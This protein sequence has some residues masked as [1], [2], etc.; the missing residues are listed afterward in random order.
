MWNFFDRK[1]CLTADEK[2]WGKA[3]KEFQ[4]V[5]LNDV[6]KFNALPHIGPH[7]SFNASTRQ[8]L[9]DF[10]ESGSQRLLFLE[11]D[12]EFVSLSHL[13]K[14]LQELP[15]DWDIFYLGGNISEESFRK[16]EKYGAHLCRVFNCWTTHAVGYS[17]KV[18]ETILEQ[19]PGFSEQMYDTYLSTR[20]HEFNTYIV[21]PM[22]AVQRSRVSSIW[23]TFCD[24]KEKFEASN[25]AMAV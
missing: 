15:A 18:I 19:Q 16:P 6:Q 2:E 3:V 7:Q 22:V 5:G 14:A 1:V 8:I 23:G 21:N 10:C 4:R 24:Y 20:L 11:E 13:T 9:I 17:R 12:C 25:K